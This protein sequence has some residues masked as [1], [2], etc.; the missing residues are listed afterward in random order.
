M[1]RQETGAPSERRGAGVLQQ[2]RRPWPPRPLPSAAG[3][4]GRGLHSPGRPRAAGGDGSPSP[5]HPGSARAPVRVGYQIHEAAEHQ[6]RIWEAG[7]QQGTGEVLGPVCRASGFPCAPGGCWWGL[8]GL[9]LLQHS[10]GWAGAGA[11][12]GDAGAGGRRRQRGGCSSPVVGEEP[13]CWRHQGQRRI[14]AAGAPG[15]AGASSAWPRESGTVLAACW[16][17]SSALL[18]A[19]PLRTGRNDA[20]HD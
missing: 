18:L 5:G 14:P 15:A 12:P 20:S 2:E 13:R 17:P 6:R 10:P 4:R 8:P 11:S 7:G 3:T 1:G 19:E 16:N 9:G